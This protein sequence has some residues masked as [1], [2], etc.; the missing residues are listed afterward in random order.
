[1]LNF[2]TKLKKPIF[3]LAPMAG[4]T[5][6]AFR[7]ICKNFGADV[8]Y[9][10]M[11]SATALNYNPIKTLKILESNKKE[12]PYVIQLFGSN[13]T[14]FTKAVKILTD[15]KTISE[16]KKEGFEYC[17][18]QGIDINFGCPVKKIR[19]QGAG[20]ILMDNPKL[21]REI[22]KSVIGSTNLPVSI[23]CRSE[24]NKI[25]VLKF[26]DKINDLNIKAIMIHGRS[27]VNGRAGEINWKIIKK[28]RDHF[29]GI[30]LANGGVMTAEDACDLLQK[31]EADGIGVARGALGNPWI[32]S[33][34]PLLLQGGIRGGGIQ[35]SNKE[36]F[37]IALKHSRLAYKLKGKI[38]IIEMRKHLCCY[39]HGLPNASEL[40]EKLV[41]VN[42]LN[43][44]KKIKNKFQETKNKIQNI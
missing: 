22:I 25:N 11:A 16:C 30:I 34:I 6:S 24:V 9:S 7:Q 1:M 29:G 13:P 40:R 15:K 31:T 20:A 14:H 32:F 5:D 41:K 35:L 38:G 28:T 23:K 36:I 43:D 3:A 21:A 19:K 12:A 10:E 26:L 18:P 42:N 2:W 44:I 4:L 27:M 17:I 8:V 37:R 39:V 33:Q